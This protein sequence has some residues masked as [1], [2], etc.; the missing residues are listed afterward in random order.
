MNYRFYMPNGKVYYKPTAVDRFYNLPSSTT[1]TRL[2]QGWS[3][4]ECA[5]NV[6]Y[7][8]MSGKFCFYMPDGTI[9][10]TAMAVDRYYNLYRGTT[11]RRLNSE[12]WT[13]ADCE[14]NERLNHKYTF[15]LPNGIVTHVTYDVDR[16]YG[17]KLR[18][19][20]SRLHS[21][22]A[23]KECAMNCRSR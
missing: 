13:I 9:L 19:T 12:G 21:G 8:T 14:R 17:L 3:T 4:E 22:W 2:R 15:H 16:F 1:A 23:E 11:N 5:R 6:R 18:T 7:N 20:G 10:K